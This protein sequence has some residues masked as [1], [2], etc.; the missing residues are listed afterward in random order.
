MTA[1]KS[2]RSKRWFV[3]V[4]GPKEFL[5]L[6]CGELADSVDVCSMLA[7]FHV[8]E[9]KEKPHIHFVIELRYERDALGPQKQSFADRVKKLFNI[10][11]K[12]QY[13]VDVW[14][15]I[16]GKGACSYLFHEEDPPILV[17]RGF[18]DQDIMEAKAANEAV[19][20]VVAINKERASNKLVD[21][22]IERFK[23]MTVTRHDIVY[24]FLQLIHAGEHYH[25]GPFRFKSLVEE[26]LIKMQTPG[27]L[28]DFAYDYE[29]SLWR[30]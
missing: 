15:G 20:A 6:K 2:V 16:R 19:Q 3:R 13:S 30:V 10:D 4:D 23:D 24:Y 22:A 29:N 11:K 1:A 8:G 9:K 25:P 26:V 12:T 17:N 7:A 5:T 14:D 28:E 27:S 21:R 18:T